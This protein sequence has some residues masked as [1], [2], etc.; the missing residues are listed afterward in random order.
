MGPKGH[1]WMIG[2]RRHALSGRLPRSWQYD[3]LPQCR[4]VRCGDTGHLGAPALDGIEL[5]RKEVAV[6]LVVTGVVAIPK[7]G[8]VGFHRTSDP[9][10][11]GS[12]RPLPVPGDQNRSRRPA[13]HRAT[14][15]VAR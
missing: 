1:P 7:E 4:D 2:V 10:S 11:S 5:S 14:R 9:M 6:L 13:L 8:R 12:F 3:P 15:V